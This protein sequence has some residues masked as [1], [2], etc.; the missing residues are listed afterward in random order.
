MDSAVICEEMVGGA[1]RLGV[2]TPGEFVREKP[3]ETT[4][5]FQYLK[6]WLEKGAKEKIG[7]N[8]ER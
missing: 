4:S 2:M 3:E 5:R 8:C 1:L 7:E 6:S